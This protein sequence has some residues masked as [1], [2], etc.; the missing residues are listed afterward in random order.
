MK[1]LPVKDSTKTYS[2]TGMDDVER[3]KLIEK[4]LTQRQKLA[5]LGLLISSIA[6]ETCNLNNCITFNTPILKEYL[7]ELVS[8]IDNYFVQHEDFEL[9]GLPYPE[10]R[11][12][13]FKILA[14][15]EHA[16]DRITE[17]SSGLKDFVRMSTSEKQV[18][19]E[20]K[21][22]I[23]RA[24]L[25]CRGEM[26]KTVRSLEVNIAEGIPPTFINPSALEQILVNILIN[27]AQAA[28]K[29]DSWVTITARQANSL[30]SHL[31]IEVSDNGCGMDEKT[32]GKIFEP[33]F[34]TKEKMK[35]SGLG[36][37]VSKNLIEGLNGHIS[38]NSIADRGSTF[39]L[40]LCT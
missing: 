12:D 2:L 1:S 8:V 27:A 3:E 5:S 4:Q 35:G 25:I 13:I 7:E 9:L 6:H 21:E 22:V 32:K 28:D 30:R 26:R 23:R 39:R 20:V 37:F 40:D 29:K 16:A 34:T 31:I 15:I 24:V 11:K 33:F 38:V 10:F 18:W 19:V 36:L 17:T 14:N